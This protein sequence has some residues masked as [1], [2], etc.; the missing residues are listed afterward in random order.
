MGLGRAVVVKNEKLKQKKESKH[1][2]LSKDKDM[3]IY[4]INW[5][6]KIEKGE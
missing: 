2:E 6:A 1:V 4:R 5:N 3:G